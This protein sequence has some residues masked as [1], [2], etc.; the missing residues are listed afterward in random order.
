MSLRD[1]YRHEQNL[2]AQL[3]GHPDAKEAAAAFVE[4]RKPVCGD[5]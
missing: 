3:A 2:T 5:G 1:G 4:K